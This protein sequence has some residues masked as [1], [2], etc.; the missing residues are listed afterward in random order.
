MTGREVGVVPAMRHEV[1]AVEHA[2]RRQALPGAAA[3]ACGENRSDGPGLTPGLTPRP[4]R[5]LF[6]LLGHNFD[7]AVRSEPGKGAVG[8]PL[9]RDEGSPSCCVSEQAPLRGKERL[10]PTATDTG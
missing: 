10:S 5:A 4:E 3:L 8:R 9:G 2:R 1:R 7:G 6:V